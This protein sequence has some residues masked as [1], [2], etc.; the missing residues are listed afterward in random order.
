M[1]LYLGVTLKGTLMDKETFVIAELLAVA[2][3]LFCIW[4]ARVIKGHGAIAWAKNLRGGKTF[5][6]MV[7]GILYV[8][9]AVMRHVGTIQ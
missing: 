9:T 6:V 5:T 2:I 4:Q 3:K 8:L 7:S 1:V